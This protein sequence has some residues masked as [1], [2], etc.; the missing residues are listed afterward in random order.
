VEWILAGKA[1]CDSLIGMGEVRIP[2]LQGQRH[3]CILALQFTNPRPVEGTRTTVASEFD[4]EVR[5]EARDSEEAQDRG[6][7]CAHEISAALAFLASAPAKVDVVSIT[8][9]HERTKGTKYTML[10]YSVGGKS[11]VPPMTVPAKDAAF[12]I[13]PK[14]ERVVRALRWIHKSHLVDN[15]LDEFTCLMV[16]FESLSQLLKQ[17]G[18]RYWHCSKCDREITQ[19]PECGETTGSKM[20]GADAMREFVVHTLGWPEKEWAAA[21]GWRCRLLH[22]DA[23]VSA[24][25]EHAVVP[26]LAPLEEA[27]IAATKKLS[28]LAPEHSPAHGRNRYP[29]SEAVL[30]LGIQVG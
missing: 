15:D 6:T 25:E 14:P 27:V 7:R 21:W 30:K 22:G 2:A 29:F 18:S 12:L 16:A 17:G 4:I 24:D 3:Y 20:S 1:K 23:D 8:N 9:D 10:C 28:G 5:F 19:C 26:F 13:A 11:E